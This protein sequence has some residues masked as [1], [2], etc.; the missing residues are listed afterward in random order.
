M[1]S[2][3]DLI[4]TEEE[5]VPEEAELSEEA[6]VPEE[7]LSEEEKTPSEEEK[8]EAVRKEV[9]EWIRTFVFAIA[10]ALVIRMFLFEMVAVHQSSMYPT[11][12]DGQK[13]GLL[14]IAY[15]VSEP[16]RGDIVVIKVSEEKNL[17]KRVIATGG[18]KV[19]IIQSRVYIDGEE[20][21]EEYISDDLVYS[22]YGPIVVPEGYIFAMGDNRPSSIDSRAMGCFPAEDVL[23][24]VCIRF[25]PFTVF[26]RIP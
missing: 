3:K 11:L 14:K 2:E 5:N 8:K 22:D 16:Q 9:L 7:E 20:L 25:V 13:V 24:R 10:L 18:Q 26:R 1:N 6:N 17:V 21:D 4:E 12:A 19:E 23:G 15:A